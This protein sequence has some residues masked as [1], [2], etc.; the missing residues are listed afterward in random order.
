MKLFKHCGATGPGWHEQIGISVFGGA[1]GVVTALSVQ[2]PIFKHPFS[3]GGNPGR[4]YSQLGGASLGTVGSQILLRGEGRRHVGGAQKYEHPQTGIIEMPWGWK[5]SFF[6]FRTEQKRKNENKNKWRNLIVASPAIC[7][8]WTASD[9]TECALVRSTRHIWRV[10]WIA[11]TIWDRQSTSW[12]KKISLALTDRQW[13]VAKE[14][15]GCACASR[16]AWGGRWVAKNAG[17]SQRT[18]AKRANSLSR[19][20]RRNKEQSKQKDYGHRWWGVESP[21]TNKT[22][23][24][25]WKKKCKKTKKKNL[26]T[27]ATFE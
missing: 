24:K 20:K 18:F 17:R 12:R 11:K 5:R 6:F 22:G 4:Q 8:S 14:S 27:D 3:P 21:S 23:M 26:H 2:N 9:S 1:P 7:A 25:S 19:H 16:V 13:D 15:S 10:V